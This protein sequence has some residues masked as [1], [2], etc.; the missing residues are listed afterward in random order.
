MT[1]RRA[2]PLLVTGTI[3]VAACGSGDGVPA[4]AAV[5]VPARAAP[6]ADPALAGVS[7]D[8]FGHRLLAA[9]SS[10]KGADENMIVS[11]LSVAIALGMVEPGTSGDGTTQLHELLGI[12]DPVAWH[13]SMNALEQSLESRTAPPVDPALGEGQAPGELLI[14]VANAAFLRPG[15]PFRPAYLEAVGTNYGAALEELDFSD[16]DGAAERIN[17]FIAGATDDHITDLVPPDAIDPGATVLALVN[18][19]LLQASWQ[20]EFDAAQTVESGAVTRQQGL[21]RRGL[22]AVMRGAPEHDAPRAQLAQE[23]GRGGFVGIKRVGHRW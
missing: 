20:N 19:L 14:R 13:A 3:A 5:P 2:L 11:P 23:G 21:R 8:I 7:V 16:P 1:S 15:Y 22:D 9:A 18:A 17:A 12:D 10:T 6:S 4:A